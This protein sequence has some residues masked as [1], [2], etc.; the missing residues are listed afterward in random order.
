MSPSRPRRLPGRPGHCRRKV[1][2]CC[3]R[4]LNAWSAPGVHVKLTLVDVDWVT[5]SIARWSCYCHG[6]YLQAAVAVTSSEHSGVEVEVDLTSIHWEYWSQKEV[7]NKNRATSLPPHRPYDCAIDLR[8]GTTPPRGRLYSLSVPEIKATEDYIEA[9][10]RAGQIRP[11]SSSCPQPAWTQ[12]LPRMWTPQSAAYRPPSPILEGVH[13]VECTVQYLVDWEGYGSDERSW[14]VQTRNQ[15]AREPP[16][17]ERDN[18]KESLRIIVFVVI[19]FLALWAPSFVN[20]IVRQLTYGGLK[21]RNEATNVFA[22]MARCNAVVTPALYIWGSPA[23]RNA[24][25]RAV[26]GRVC[27]KRK[28]RIGYDPNKWAKTVE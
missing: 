27:L 26:W 5:G 20:I 28:G 15:L 7:V 9:S 12:Q 16:S 10:L 23:L 3:L 8:P 1:V 2:N 25:W 6:H 14:V 22:I 19:F 11:S 4:A 13:P 17:T 24:V 21:F 18:K